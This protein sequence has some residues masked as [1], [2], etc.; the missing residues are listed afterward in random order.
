MCHE[1]AMIESI[2]KEAAFYNRARS[3][4]ANLTIWMEGGGQ[5]LEYIDEYS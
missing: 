2:K 5:A 3:E 1:K 4:P